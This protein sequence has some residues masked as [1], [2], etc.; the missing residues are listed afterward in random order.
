MTKQ[1]SV[2]V[3]EEVFGNL[4]VNRHTGQSINGYLKDLMDR[5][6]KNKANK[7]L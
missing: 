1:H 2:S 7:K 4:K 6:K 3:S 5:D